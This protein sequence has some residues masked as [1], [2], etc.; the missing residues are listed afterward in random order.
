MLHFVAN[1]CS[2]FLISLTNKSVS[3]WECSCDI[4]W[5][6]KRRIITGWNKRGL[7]GSGPAGVQQMKLSSAWVRLCADVLLLM[8]M[9]RWDLI[10]LSV[11]T[12]VLFPP[13]GHPQAAAAASVCSSVPTNATESQPNQ[14]DSPISRSGDALLF[15]TATLQGDRRVATKSL[16]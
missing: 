7:R 6:S 8:I 11:V 15:M 14:W 9:G 5:S 16:C 1:C 4:Y 13:V 3:I 12:D 2:L 10:V